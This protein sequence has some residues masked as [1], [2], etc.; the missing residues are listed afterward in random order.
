MRAR[1]VPDA[2]FRPWMGSGSEQTAAVEVRP[3]A[4]ALGL[5]QGLVR[6]FLR[7]RMVQEVV[8]N[9]VHAM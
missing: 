5:G 3:E 7:Q 8:G 1:S 2:V 6:T 4:A 9:V